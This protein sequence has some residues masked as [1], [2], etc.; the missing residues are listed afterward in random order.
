MELEELREA[1][2]RR[3]EESGRRR[4][5][6]WTSALDGDTTRVRSLPSVV[7]WHASRPPKRA[8]QRATGGVMSGLRS[9]GKEVVA[10]VVS[11]GF[12]AGGALLQVGV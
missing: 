5:L 6:G 11:L 3:G 12:A 9:R 10:G 4:S 8:M 7:T 2:K 1:T